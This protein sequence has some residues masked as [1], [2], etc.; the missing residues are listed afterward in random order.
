MSK[1]LTPRTKKDFT[2]NREIGSGDR[3]R[4]FPSIEIIAPPSSARSILI[5]SSLLALDHTV[6]R[7]AFIA[8]SSYMQLLNE[9]LH[10]T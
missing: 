9:A 1:D 4:A 8:Q 3:T 2:F 10:F 5:L 7:H 6:G